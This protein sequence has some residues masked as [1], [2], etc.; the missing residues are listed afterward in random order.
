MLRLDATE[1]ENAGPV[2]CIRWFGL[3][4]LSVRAALSRAQIRC[5]APPPG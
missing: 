3:E 5:R 2:N 4:T 1:G